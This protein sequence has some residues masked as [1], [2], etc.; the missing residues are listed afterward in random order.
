MLAYIQA[1]HLKLVYALLPEED[2]AD[3]NVVFKR[4][5]NYLIGGQQCADCLYALQLHIFCLAPDYFCLDV[6]TLCPSYALLFTF[7]NSMFHF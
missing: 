6:C 1:R 4:E 7:L 3:R 5:I 2:L